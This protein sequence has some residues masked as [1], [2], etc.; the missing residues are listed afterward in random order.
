MGNHIVE[1]FFTDGNL[2]GA[3]YLELLEYT[4]DST[5]REIV[6]NNDK[7]LEDE[8]MFQQTGTPPH[9]AVKVREFVSDRFYARWICRRAE[10]EWTARSPNLNSLD[11]FSDF[12]RNQLFTPLNPKIS[13]N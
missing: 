9:Y 7:L 4:I 5:I 1:P 10:I 6:E 13:V 3:T 2:N 8:I 11:F 12:I